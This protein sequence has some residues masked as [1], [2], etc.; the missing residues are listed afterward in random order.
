[1]TVV[2]LI[3]ILT[4]G[5][6]GVWEN[7]AHRKTKAKLDFANEKRKQMSSRLVAAQRVA[8]KYERGYQEALQPVEEE[9]NRYYAEVLRLEAMLDRAGID[10]GPGVD[11][12]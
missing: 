6:L 1:M 8:Q 3:L 4:L 11:Q 12:S 2:L 10:Y 5:G 9:A 7:L